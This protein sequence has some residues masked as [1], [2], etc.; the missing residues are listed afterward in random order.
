MHTHLDYEFY[1]ELK[2]DR[3]EIRAPRAYYLSIGFAFG[4]VVAMTL[5]SRISESLLQ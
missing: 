2:Y 4:F 1:P 3:R 5:F